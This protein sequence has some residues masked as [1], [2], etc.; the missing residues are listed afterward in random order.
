MKTEER[1]ELW[2]DVMSDVHPIRRTSFSLT[3]TPKHHRWLVGILGLLM[4]AATEE[5]G[6]HG[7]RGAPGP[8][9][10]RRRA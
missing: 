9:E 5:G 4:V 6:L 2:D 7:V 1:K 3:R 8:P 10:L